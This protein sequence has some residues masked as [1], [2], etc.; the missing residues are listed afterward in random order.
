MIGEIPALQ[1]ISAAVTPVVMLSACGTLTISVNSRQQHLSEKIRASAAESRTN[2]VSPERRAQLHEQIAVFRQRFLFSWLASI[3]LYGAIGCFLATTLGILW[4]QR[5]LSSGEPVLLAFFVVGL[6]LMLSASCFV[7][8]EVSYS[9]RTL[10]LEMRDLAL[11]LHRPHW[12]GRRHE[13]E[14]QNEPED[15]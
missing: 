6:L 3:T 10:D 1:T 9:W 8:A 11:P 14:P 2:L 13:E 12:F 7:V 5:G 4:T 15:L